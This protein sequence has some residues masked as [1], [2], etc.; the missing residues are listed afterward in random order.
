MADKK[1]IVA[2]KIFETVTDALSKGPNIRIVFSR[3]ESRKIFDIVDRRIVNLDS[4]EVMEKFAP[5][6][7]MT[8][9]AT[10][11]DLKEFA[12]PG[13]KSWELD[14]AIISAKK[15]SLHQSKKVFSL[16]LSRIVHS[17]L[18]WPSINFKISSRE[19]ETNPRFKESLWMEEFYLHL[20]RIN[21]PAE[22]I[23]KI[24]VQED[25]PIVFIPEKLAI[26][27]TLPLNVQE[28]YVLSRIKGRQTP[29]QIEK[30]GEIPSDRMFEILAIFHRAG[31]LVLE[32]E[33]MLQPAAKTAPAA[34]PAESA[35]DLSP[36]PKSAPPPEPR[37]DADEVNLLSH[38]FTNLKEELEAR[39]YYAILEVS[40]ENFSIS[41]LK[42]NYYKYA[43]LYHPDKYRKYGS[44]ELNTLLE[45]ILNQFNAAYETLKDPEKKQ[46]YD[47]ELNLGGLKPS[48]AT[49][50]QRA[51]Q[52]NMDQVARESFEQGKSLI[53]AQHYAEA[54]PNLKRA[55][56][57]KPDNPDYQA[58]L[59]YAMSKTVQFRRESEKYFLRAIEINPMN[60]N[61]HLHLGRMYKEARMYSK[62]IAAFQEALQWDPENKLALQEIDE[63][64]EATGKKTKG[65]FGNLFRNK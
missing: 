23:E 6:L 39:D 8:K 50:G 22:S 60:V 18:E 64:N 20:L 32:S 55:I 3:D 40:R 19:T 33:A 25:S 13:L 58:Y 5:L 4:T 17:M 27:T 16:Q 14:D 11:D 47:E 63:I 28:G 26:M 30:S 12:L 61:T 48:I 7:I 43:K 49:G 24:R 42:T 62:A 57:I 56:A 65:F 37:A 53:A 45:S 52:V 2:A 36:D 44:E 10:Q 9:L 35:P 15:L 54:I 46:K 34:Q 59:G 21:P 51:V 29:V 1:A 38:N 41:M 31:F